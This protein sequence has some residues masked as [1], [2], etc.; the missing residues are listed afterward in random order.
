MSKKELKLIAT[1]LLSKNFDASNGLPEEL[2]E[3][4]SSLTPIP[5]VDLLIIKDKKIL[6]SWRDDQYYGKGWHLPGGCIRFGETMQNRILETAKKELKCT[7]EFV[8]EPI[9][10][11]DIII[12]KNTNLSNPFVRGHNITILFKCFLPDN[13]IINNDK[14]NETDVGYLKWFVKIPGNLLDV[15][16]AYGDILFKELQKGT[17]Y[18]KLGK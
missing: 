4:V 16:D 17:E 6:L 8:P 14:L 11:R 5:N 10:V 18:D 13:Y 12:K 3:L 2:F 7:V 9:A 1:E 15:H